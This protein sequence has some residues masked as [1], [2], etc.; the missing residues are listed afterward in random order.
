MS[1][2]ATS[3]ESAWE[4]I[5]QQYEEINQGSWRASEDDIQKWRHAGADY[6]APLET[7]AR[8]GFAIFDYLTRKSVDK[9]LPMKLD[10]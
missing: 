1:P 2:Q 8:F 6:G 4:T 10:Y 5:V 9:G 3:H 7:S